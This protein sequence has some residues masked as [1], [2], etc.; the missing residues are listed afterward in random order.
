MK[1]NEPYY[2]LIKLLINTQQKQT[3]VFDGEKLKLFFYIRFTTLPLCV[4]GIHQCIIKN[5]KATREKIFFKIL[6]PELIKVM[7]FIFGNGTRLMKGR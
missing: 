2:T 7:R 6:G 5:I 3:C 4:A 1:G